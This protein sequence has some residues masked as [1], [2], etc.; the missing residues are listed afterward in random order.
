MA[1]SNSPDR[2]SVSEAARWIG[3]TRQTLAKWIQDLGYQ[4]D[5]KVS[6]P[7][8][9]K[10]LM[11]RERQAG[12]DE[13][14]RKFAHVEQTIEEAEAL[15][16]ISE[17]EAKRRKLVAQMTQEELKAAEMAGE[18][19]RV[20]DV[21]EEVRG[22]YAKVRGDLNLA[23]ANLGHRLAMRSQD[24][25]RQILDEWII[26]V[27]SKLQA[28]ANYRISQERADDRPAEE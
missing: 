14:R 7:E 10:A 15:G 20:S 28:D 1:H 26:D 9:V 25:C 16:W 19:V 21:A 3:V 22:E 23:P 8:I 17:D 11:A 2:C 12:A 27:L 18:V 4:H 6:V 5:G 24:E 13:A